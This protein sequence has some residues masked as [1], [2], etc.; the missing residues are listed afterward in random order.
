M[1]RDE[2]IR[3]A[4][5][6]PPPPAP[7]RR[8][9]AIAAALDRFDGTEAP[10]ARPPRTKGAGWW[11][12]LQQPRMGAL[13]AAVL[14]VGISLPIALQMAPQPVD[15]TG[16]PMASSRPASPSPA[17]TDLADAASAPQQ[18]TG[19][20]APQPSAARKD[21]AARQPSGESI[22]PVFAKPAAAPPPPARP[23]AAYVPAPPPPPPPPPRAMTQAEARGA[24]ASAKRR[25]DADTAI[26]VSA[27]RRESAAADTPV[28]VTAAPAP[29][30]AGYA[31]DNSSEIIVT[32]AARA[33][34][35]R[36]A[37]GD[38]NACTVNDPSQSLSRCTRLATKGNRKTRER[39]QAHLAEGLQKAWQ[40]DAD[41]AV[42][43]FG[44]AIAVAPQF[45]AAYLNRG[46][47]YERK[48]DLDRAL[49]DL[50]QAVRYAPAEARGFYLR[51][52]ILRQMG[53]GERARADERRAIELDRRYEAVV[54]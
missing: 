50:D 22:G 30:P 11:S 19:V 7:L 17:G 5:P 3:T 2:D 41:G 46:L 40:G 4:L 51:S 39:A 10:A 9:A 15:V 47:A 38:W 28:A 12:K 42:T 52:L 31:R 36:A 49:A 43:A 37:R 48:G 21:V 35:K 54:P 8:A 14:A 29:A 34:P 24:A 20:N 53:D 16:E 44:D 45:G 18:Q 26:I 13:V 6:G 33:A 1:D 27:R 23:P 32:G 25:D